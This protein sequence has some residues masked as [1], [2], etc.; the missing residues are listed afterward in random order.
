MSQTENTTHPSRQTMEGLRYARWAGN[1]LGILLIGIAI[2]NF[3]SGSMDT[4]TEV[5][6][7]DS[8]EQN[9]K[10]SR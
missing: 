7:R 4:L 9:T 1:F 3:S 5:F 6:Y 2:K 10:E 8:Y